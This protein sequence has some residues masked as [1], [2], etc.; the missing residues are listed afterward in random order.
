M[1]HCFGDSWVQGIGTEWEPGTGR[2]SMEDRYDRNFGWDKIY[3]KYSWPGQLSEL[4]KFKTKIKNHGLGG[5]SNQEIY[6]NVI[7]TIWS[8]ELKKGDFAIVCLSSIIRQPLPFLLVKDDFNNSDETLTGY[9]NYSNSCFSYFKQG[10]D[11][12]VHWLETINDKKI[13]NATKQV[14]MDYLV[15]RFDYEFLYETNMNYIC[16]LQ[17][18]FEE[19]GVDYLFVNAF[20][21]NI[22][23]NVKFYNR[24]KQDKWILFDYTLQEYL[25]DK[26]K[27]FDISLGYSVWEDDMIDVEK[28]QD[29]PHPNRIGH[30][31]IAELICENI[32]NK[33]IKY[34]GII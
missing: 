14:Y 23:K 28:N 1:I 9:I 11:N 17:I 19:L 10:R 6:K 24:I 16:N 12:G 20:E 34:D 21:N 5:N 15:N 32:K 30:K 4:L 2:I 8:G 27:D 13:K 29:G 25:L 33:S 22:S 3:K 26:S 31:I 18:Y 7:N